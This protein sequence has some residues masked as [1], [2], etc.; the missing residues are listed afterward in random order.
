MRA[1]WWNFGTT[2][3]EQR[4]LRPRDGRRLLAGIEANRLTFGQT[5]E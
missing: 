1:A 5:F 3:G 2:C 4:Q